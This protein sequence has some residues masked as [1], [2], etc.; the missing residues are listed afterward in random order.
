MWEYLTEHSD[1]LLIGIA[2]S[3]VATALIWMLRKVYEKVTKAG[4]NFH[5]TLESLRELR[6]EVMRVSK[7][8]RYIEGL[9]ALKY[10]NRE[11]AAILFAFMALMGTSIFAQPLEQILCWV[12]IGL[13][14]N[15]AWLLSKVAKG[16]EDSIEQVEDEDLEKGRGL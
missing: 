5:K 7:H 2:G 3:I 13:A 9:E 10:R 6:V 16:I 1:S 14:A 15:Y 12:I 4:R 11:N 8:R